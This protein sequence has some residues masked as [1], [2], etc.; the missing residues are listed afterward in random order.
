[1]ISIL[2]Y[3]HKFPSTVDWRL[4]PVPQTTWPNCLASLMGGTTF[5][6]HDLRLASVA[7]LLHELQ[8][9]SNACYCRD[10]QQFLL[11]DELE[12]Q[13]SRGEI[14]FLAQNRKFI[15]TSKFSIR[16]FP[17]QPA[18]VS[19]SNF[20]IFYFFIFQLFLIRFFIRFYIYFFI[21]QHIHFYSFLS[22]SIIHFIYNLYLYHNYTLKNLIHYKQLYKNKMSQ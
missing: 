8:L 9:I 18:V 22:S 12:W 16:F 5:L 20:S 11:L 6:A 13:A 19:T 2:G 7:P 17:P 10:I 14:M 4:H 15:C 21:C 1:M 3:K